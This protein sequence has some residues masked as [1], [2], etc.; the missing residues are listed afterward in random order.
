[1]RPRLNA[2]FDLSYKFFKLTYNY[3][4]KKNQYD[5]KS[6]KIVKTK[7]VGLWGL[8]IKKTVEDY[9][10]ELSLNNLLNTSYN[11]VLGYTSPGRELQFEL[12]KYF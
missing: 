9:D 1:M 6:Y 11:E 7:A 8:N 12:T 3:H 10:F 4:S 5:P 2:Q